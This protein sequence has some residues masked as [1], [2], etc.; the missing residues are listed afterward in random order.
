MNTQ[1]KQDIKELLKQAL[2]ERSSEYT[3]KRYFKLFRKDYKDFF[4]NKITIIFLPLIVISYIT[5]FMFIQN[6]NKTNIEILNNT[7]SKKE[8]H[9]QDLPTSIQ[10]KYILESEKYELEELI[11]ANE[12][13][14]KNLVKKLEIN[15]KA[16]VKK[17][18]KIKI[19]NKEATNTNTLNKKIAYLQTQLVSTKKSIKK[20]KYTSIT[21]STTPIGFKSMPKQC[22]SKFKKFLKQN[23][24]NSVRFQIIPLLDN[25]DDKFIKD[26]SN[27]R[28]KELLKFGLS[29]SRVLEAA[30]LVKDTLG[31]TALISY[32]SYIAHSKTKRGII[33]RAYK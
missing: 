33:I 8:L 12:I 1:D 21:C 30:W 11:T 2:E 4:S 31:K 32:V 29:R 13:E 19:N 27:K 7:I 5:I 24:K 25:S 23:S 22:V 10:N 28:T 3:K 16:L 17:A 26:N 15:K 20:Q 14:I 9:F 6:K 18:K